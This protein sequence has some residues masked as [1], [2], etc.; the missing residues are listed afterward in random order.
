MTNPLTHIGGATIA[1]GC[2]ALMATSRIVDVLVAKGVIT[3]QEAGSILTAIA[4]D[5]RDVAGGSSA[6]EAADR[7]VSILDQMADRY[8]DR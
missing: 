5:T 6:D 2:L 7:L 8:L 4:E 3:K 1:T